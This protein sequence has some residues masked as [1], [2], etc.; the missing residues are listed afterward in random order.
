MPSGNQRAPSSLGHGAQRGQGPKRGAENGHSLV[1]H[2]GD[3]AV[4]LGL[5][6]GGN[7]SSLSSRTIADRLR[8]RV[9]SAI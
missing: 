3:E 5:E 4:K 8:L 7:L 1:T 2:R 6:R 9:Q